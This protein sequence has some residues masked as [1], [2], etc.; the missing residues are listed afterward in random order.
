MRPSRNQELI[1]ALALEIKS[2]RH[3]LAFS[4]EELASR[5]DVDRPY[6]SLMEVGRKQPTISVLFRL[7]IA[8][9]LTFEQFAG[10]VEARYRLES[11]QQREAG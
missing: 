7:A 8:L 11:D 3:E 9:D 5:M 6:L 4:Q 1:N 10:R 2:R